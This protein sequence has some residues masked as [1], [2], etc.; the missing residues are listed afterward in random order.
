MKMMA[1]LAIAASVL[2]L[3]AG[4]V[5]LVSL[6]RE[7]EPF[8]AERSD[9][10]GFWAG[11]GGAQLTVREDGTAAGVKMP[12]GFDGSADAV[13]GT[14]SGSGTW[15]MSKR[16][17]SLANQEIRVTLQTGPTEKTTLDVGAYGQ[18]A[19]HGLYLSVSADTEEMF[20][21]KK[22]S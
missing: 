10:V 17:T 15:S 2:T 3:A 4:G 5:L 7:S 8:K 12:S 20:V 6:I 9:F 22:A 11:P 19:K 13:V 14:V 21:L 16:H 1:R 18:G